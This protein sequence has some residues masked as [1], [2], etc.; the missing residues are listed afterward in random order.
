MTALARLTA[1]P[2][3][4]AIARTH[5]DW[6]VRRGAVQ[7]LADP[8]ALAAVASSDRDTDVRRAA[9][10]LLDEK[11]VANVVRSA[12]TVEA[13]EQAVG[14]LTDQAILADVA[15]ESADRA[16][17]VRAIGGL[18]D[19]KTLQSI[20]ED[21][22]GPELREAALARSAQLAG[23]VADPRNVEIRAILLDPVM[24]GAYRDLK[25]RFQI[26]T[27][28]K[29]YVKGGEDVG[30]PVQKGK[31]LL[32]NVRVTID[33]AGTVLFRRTYRGNKPK[34]AESFNPG[35]AISGGYLVRVNRAELDLLEICEA[36]L[37]PL[38]KEQWLRAA[39]S[40][41]KYISTA[42]ATLVD[43]SRRTGVA[44]VSSDD[45]GEDDGD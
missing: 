23:Q 16:V 36:L 12:A 28:E 19:P 38:G 9:L 30:D 43:S 11:A 17:R 4:E 33:S 40:K 44:A 31:V 41:N 32:E 22:S 10:L 20:A 14:F 15:R 29:R 39:K 6:V 27:D 25:L 35:A 1:P 7:R 24:R 37:E 2:A 3:L 5:A 26:W 13:R 42:A 8:K 18:S 21:E 34:K 45:G